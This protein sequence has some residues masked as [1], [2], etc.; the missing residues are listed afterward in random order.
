MLFVLYLNTPG[1]GFDY[2][3]VTL[4]FTSFSTI[5]HWPYLS[6]TFSSGK[7]SRPSHVLDQV[8]SG[9]SSGVTVSKFQQLGNLGQWFVGLKDAL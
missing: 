4:S 1:F 9:H 7:R 5:F 8:Q 3:A 2:V 6:H